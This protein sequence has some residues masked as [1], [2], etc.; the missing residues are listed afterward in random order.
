MKKT[1]PKLHAFGASGDGKPRATS[2]QINFSRQPCHGPIQLITLQDF[3]EHGETLY[4]LIHLQDNLTRR[5][6]I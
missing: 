5:V 4:L 3:R 1:F 2:N 6:S